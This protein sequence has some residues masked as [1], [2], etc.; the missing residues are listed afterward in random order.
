MKGH[1]TAMEAPLY[2]SYQVYI[3]NK[4]RARSAIHLGM[5]ESTIQ[6]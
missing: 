6:Y 4:V 1:M 5:N 3:I 2:Q